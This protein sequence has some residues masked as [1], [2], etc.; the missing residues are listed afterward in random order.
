VPGR[1]ATARAERA[2]RAAG[3]DERHAG[4]LDRRAGYGGSWPLRR[5]R[6][7]Q[8]CEG[9]SFSGSR[10]AAREPLQ[11]L[12]QR[13]RAEIAHRRGR[14]RRPLAPDL[15]GPLEPVHDQ[16]A[17]AQPLDRCLIRSVR[18][19]QPRPIAP[20]DRRGADH[21]QLRKLTQGQQVDR[22][23]SM[24]RSSISPPAGK[25]LLEPPTL[26]AERDQRNRCFA[27]P[28]PTATREPHEGL[29]HSQPDE[30]SS[31]QRERPDRRRAAL[32]RRVAAAAPIRGAGAQRRC[33][34]GQA[35]APCRRSVALG[36]STRRFVR[37]SGVAEGGVRDRVRHDVV[38][39]A[40][41]AA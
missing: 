1:C 22:D 27:S 10:M 33:V 15:L 32:C 4:G 34:E 7:R 14:R 36:S 16:P 25:T 11:T 40:V 13:T 21:V 3:L 29:L 35:N 23:P 17:L 28:P 37:G 8:T 30:P 26:N 2:Q 31:D 41:V 18:R 39:N 12:R 6:V 38:R 5:R 19:D 24:R 9:R 20:V